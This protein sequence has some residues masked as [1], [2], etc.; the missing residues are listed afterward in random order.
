[1][2]SYK[3]SI[4]YLY[5]LQK[6]GIKLGLE[7]PKAILSV[8]SNPHKD[9]PSI[10]IAGT[11]GKGSVSAMIASILMAHG[12]KVGLYTSPHLISF[13]ERIRI[14]NEQI[15]EYDVIELTKEIRSK[16]EDSGIATPT[17]FEFV[18]AMAFIYF[19][20]KK[21]DWAVIE[22]GMGGRLDATN[23]I[24]PEVSVIT[25]ISYDHKE[26]LGDTIEKIAFEKAGIIK[27][28]V[29]VII[30]DQQPE[31][32]R[33]LVETA[34]ERSS[35]FFIYGK[36]FRGEIKDSDIYGL[37]IDYKD[38][39]F[40]INNI[41]CPLPGKH[42]LTNASV[43]IKAVSK[44]L[45]IV[46]KEISE[47]LL[48]KGISDTKWRGRLEIVKKKPLIMVDGAH[49]PDAAEV[50]SDFI[51]E[52]LKGYK[53]TLIIGVMADKDVDGI[54]KPLLPLASR[55]I[56]TSPRYERAMNPQRL[57]E[58]ASAMGYSSI[59]TRSVGESLNI[60]IGESDKEDR[61]QIILITGSF[62][63]IGEALEYLGEK[64]ILSTLRERV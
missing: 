6:H 48:K 64:Q 47:D 36:D 40:S 28:R 1:M 38:D 26:F 62:Y 8:F 20:R 9:F 43:S 27:E 21:V 13:T 15:S 52:N 46:G 10:H 41:F 44:A 35:P 4:N 51:K 25:K 3:E 11:N 19:S 61:R 23:I 17:F 54:I 32:E 55:I 31:A 5:S 7:K 63:T 53:I 33:V 60:A 12:F 37:T 49:N 59:I 56:F 45:R 50:L 58:I 30:S 2:I 22:T 18:T 29:P 24:T 39:Q 16:I 42:Q 57:S 14:N 34:K